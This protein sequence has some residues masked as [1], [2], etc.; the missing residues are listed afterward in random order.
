ML[1]LFCFPLGCLLQLQY[2]WSSEL[3]GFQIP[4]P[5]QN[6]YPAKGSKCNLKLRVVQNKKVVNKA[7]LWQFSVPLGMPFFAA[8]LL[9]L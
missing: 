1:S 7:M 6:L 5:R 8:V 3:C 4:N 9:E 2:G